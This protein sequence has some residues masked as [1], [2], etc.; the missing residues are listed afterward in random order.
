MA[1]VGEQADMLRA[2]GQALD[3][4]GAGRVEIVYHEAFVS[5][6]WP[7]G[8]AHEGHTSYQEH[9]LEQLRARGREMRQGLSAGGPV[10][11]RAE[12]LR[13]LG[14]ELDQKGI[15]M[16]SVVEEADGLLVSGSAAG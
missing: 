7:E 2:L 11:L 1:N 3:R 13:T 6:A 12:L 9:D 16:M 8:P 5:V 14:Q 15:E 10:S 4:A